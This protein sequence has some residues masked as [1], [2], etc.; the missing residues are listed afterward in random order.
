M[1]SKSTWKSVLAPV[2]YDFT[3]T[4]DLT[5]SA[6]NVAVQKQQPATP[7]DRERRHTPTYKQQRRCTQQLMACLAPLCIGAT[8]KPLPTSICP[9]K[10]VHHWC[11]LVRRVF[12]VFIWYIIGVYYRWSAGGSTPPARTCVR[13]A[14]TPITAHESITS[15]TLYMTMW[16]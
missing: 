5:V 3:W 7:P 2:C 11:K 4:L 14:D 1:C 9:H 13:L 12:S 8:C 15:H 6:G 10:E 16:T